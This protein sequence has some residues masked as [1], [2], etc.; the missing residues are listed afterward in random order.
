MSKLLSGNGMW[1]SSRMIL[2][3]HK[4]RILSEQKEETKRKKPIFH[5]D[6]LEDLARNIAEYAHNKERVA[7][8]TFGTYKNNII[9]GLIIE[10]SE[11]KKAIRIQ[12][13]HNN[14][15]I[16]LFEIIKVEKKR[17]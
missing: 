10:V 7:I 11:Q 17:E 15:W 14:R 2:P 9:E 4:E 3:Q 5:E 16:Q 13:E 1:E 12:S 6:E 8:T